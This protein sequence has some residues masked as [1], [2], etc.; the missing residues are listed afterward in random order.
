MKSRFTAIVLS[1]LFIFSFVSCSAEEVEVKDI[2]GQGY[3]KNENTLAVHFI[4]VGQGDSE[5]V[6]FPNGKTMLIDAGEQD[7]G[8][9]VVAYLN[10]LNVSVIDYVVATHPH[11]DH[12]GG[13]P[14]VFDAFDIKAVYMPN[15]VSDSYSFELLLDKIEAEGCET[16]EAKQGVS[17]FA[18]EN[19]NARFLA[20]VSAEYDDLNNYSA[21]LKI[22]Y[23][24]NSFLFMGDAETLSEKEITDVVS[25]DVIKV[26]HHGSKTSSSKSFINR[27]MPRYAV[28][29]VGAD[30]SYGHPNA[31]VIDRYERIGA[32]I[33]RT[34]EIGT[35]VLESDGGSLTDITNYV[36][37]SAGIAPSGDIHTESSTTDTGSIEAAKYVLNTNSKKI[38]LSGCPSASNISPQNKKATNETIEELEKQGYTCCKSCNPK[39]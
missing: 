17:I 4:D 28:F 29:E 34:D 39:G 10:K 14:A 5:F 36:M 38:H 13:L 7:A 20:P 24:E 15:A 3:L 35:I 2:T 31:E 30:N 32:E 26:G 33:L 1:L 11:S 16:I 18:D 8:E 37:E 12:I 19:L 25:A 6:E 27:V 23:I 9:D 21:V 22:T